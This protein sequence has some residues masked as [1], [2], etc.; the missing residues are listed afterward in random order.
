[1]KATLFVL[2]GSHPS[3]SARLMLE[4]KGI[5]YRRLDLIPVLHRGILKAA[6]FKG[7]TV[8][9]L[10]LDG[11][12][13][14]GT[15]AIARALESAVPEP[16]LLP[17]E[18]ER[19]ATVEQ[20]ERWGDE[21]LQPIPR[22]IIWN[23][24]GRDP[25]GRRSYLEGARLGLPVGLAAKTAPPLVKMA[26]RFNRADD[27][28]VRRDLAALPETLDHVDGLIAD[29]VIGG[30]EPNVAD[31]QIAPSVRLLMTLDDVRPLIEGRPCAELAMR[32]VPDYPGYAPA[33][34]PEAWKPAASSKSAA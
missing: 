5:D 2:P 7:L 23:V 25:R 4:R 26:K 21:V 9:A 30:E 33:A 17:A 20:A 28:A 27:E 19:R 29:G 32:L 11:A 16:S 18:P 22:R 3:M 15:I 1:V 13:I 24:L 10:R 12:R 14:Q 6:G 31:F 8:P 34:L